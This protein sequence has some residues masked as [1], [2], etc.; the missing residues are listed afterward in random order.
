MA[1]A[2][3]TGLT[4]DDLA[5]MPD[6]DLYELRDGELVERAMSPKSAYVA[7]EIYAHLR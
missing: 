2:T 1:T 7:G 3:K 5:A 6:G 4:V